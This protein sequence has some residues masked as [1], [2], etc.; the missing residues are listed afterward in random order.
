MMRYTGYELSRKALEIIRKTRQSGTPDWVTESAYDLFGERM[1]IDEFVLRIINEV[2]A[3][4][5]RSVINLTEKIEGER[6]E[7]VVVPEDEMKNAY[8]ETPSKLRDSLERMA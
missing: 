6:I 4:G 3:G 2:R 5:D 1:G 8:K 7:S